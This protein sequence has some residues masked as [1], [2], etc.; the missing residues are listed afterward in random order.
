MIEVI[1]LVANEGPKVGYFLNM[2]KGTYLMGRCESLE[3]ATE[4]KNRLVT[5]G[6]NE[7]SIRIHPDNDPTS[8]YVVNVLGTLIGDDRLIKHELISSKIPKL[9]A[10]IEAIKKFKDPQSQHLLLKWCL[11]M[12]INKRICRSI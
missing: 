4:R 1:D 5:L 9:R 3:I 8:N 6:I 7:S 11:S 2:D 12:K 10:E